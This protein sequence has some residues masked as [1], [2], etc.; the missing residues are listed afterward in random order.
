MIAFADVS[1]KRAIHIFSFLSV[2]LFCNWGKH[3]KSGGMLGGSSSGDIGLRIP[4]ET[5][6]GCA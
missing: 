5:V 1:E 2:T 6:Q 3:E 4:N